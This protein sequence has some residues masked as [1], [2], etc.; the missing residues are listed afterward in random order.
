MIPLDIYIHTNVYCYNGIVPLIYTYTNVLAIYCIYTVY[1]SAGWEPPIDPGTFALIGAAAFLGGVVRMTVSLTV[2]LIESTDEIEYGLPLLVT[3]MVAKWV[4]DL[5]NEGLYDIHIE[6]KEVP[7]LGW[8]SP[9]KVDRYVLLRSG[10][11]YSIYIY[12]RLNAADV[13]NPDLKYIYPISRVSSIERLLRVTA[14]NAFLVV[15]PLTTP[16]SP[17]MNPRGG[18]SP[19][20]PQLYERLSIHPPA[21]RKKMANLR[22]EAIRKSQQLGHVNYISEERGAT[23]VTYTGNEGRDDVSL[24]FHGIILRS[25]L[26]ELLRNKVFFDENDGVSD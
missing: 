1:R 10:V 24:V 4:G 14:H 17:T 12:D 7:L 11:N 2:I 16:P 26:V 5:F 19:Q 22:K 15:S 18:D 20:T 13:M 9:E 23:P 6:V 25:Q 3:L 8:D 21:Y